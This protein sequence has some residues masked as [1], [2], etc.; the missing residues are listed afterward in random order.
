MKYITKEIT[1][2]NN[3]EKII[4]TRFIFKLRKARFLNLST[5]WRRFRAA[6]IVETIQPIN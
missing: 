6:V 3:V 5:K 2:R 1:R 4:R